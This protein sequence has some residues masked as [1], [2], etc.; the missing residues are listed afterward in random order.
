MNL[1][2]QRLILESFK[3]YQALDL[4]LAALAP[5]GLY[6]LT[7]QNLAEPRLGANGC[8][9]TGL[10]QGFCW[11]WHGT[12][13]EGLKTTDLRPRNDKTNP[14]G[15]L[16]LAV[17]GQVKRLARTTS[18]N[19]I[20]LDRGDTTQEVVEALLGIPRD[21]CFHTIVLAQGQPLF[22]DLKPREKMG[23]LNLVLRLERWEVR[24]DKARKRASFLGQQLQG[25]EADLTGLLHNC[26]SLETT[27]VRVETQSSEWDIAHSKAL[28]DL[29]TRE[30]TARG[31]LDAA[32]IAL[33]RAEQAS[34]GAGLEGD[35]ERALASRLQEERATV[36]KAIRSKSLEVRAAESELA[37][38]TTALQHLVGETCPTCNQPINNAEVARQRKALEGQ[39]NKLTEPDRAGLE[40]LEQREAQ[41]ETEI[42]RARAAADQ[43]NK[44]L[45]ATETTVRTARNRVADLTATLKTT[46][47]QLKQSMGQVNPYRPQ[48]IE[49]RD[50]LQ[51][52]EA[53]VARLSQECT[54]AQREEA[55]AQFWA[56]GFK[57]VCL[58]LIEETLQQMEV[59]ANA[60]LAEAGLEGWQLKLDIERE[61]KAGTIERG[62]NVS[63]IS[64]SNS[65]PVRWDTWS[66]GEQQRLR[67][68]A[69]HALSDVLLGSLGVNPSLEIL[70]E[71]TQHLSAEGIADMCGYLAARAQ[72]LNRTILYVDH[73]ARESRLFAGVLRV[74][75]DRMGSY[76]QVD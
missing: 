58:F 71:P 3:S 15:A 53:E 50:Q 46:Q 30:Q 60:T 54:A 65:S 6:Y 57:D 49:L 11:V 8:G 74:T 2:F 67:L 9:K 18:P 64:P 34:E 76:V 25:Y 17:D 14:S 63:V 43:F 20:T 66:G 1:Q 72:R 29:Q 68:I 35:A 33:G 22:L 61:T 19:H 42:A 75:R 41:L 44:R 23:L 36:A 21:V 48:L 69:S 24:A 56:T 12:T 73:T 52:A 31:Q 39:K 7:G 4:D 26:T 28:T 27:L 47:A 32:E 16:V 5:G 70:D 38:I 51:T 59:I 45:M 10:I 37:R 40:T 55:E 13:P 62:I